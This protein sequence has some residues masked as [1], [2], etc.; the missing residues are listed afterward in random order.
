ML[1]DSFNNTMESL[2]PGNVFKNITGAFRNPGLLAN[3]IPAVIGIGAGYV[4]NKFTN[5]FVRKTGMSRFKRVL[6]TLALYGV[7]R[8]LVKNPEVNKYFGRRLAQNVFS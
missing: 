7:S 3:I 8:A 2:K 1:K 4:S 6:M 5:R